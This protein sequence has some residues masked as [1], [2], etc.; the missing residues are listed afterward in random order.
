MTYLAWVIKPSPPPQPRHPDLHRHHLTSSTVAASPRPPPPSSNLL[1]RSR[2]THKFEF[3][4]GERPARWFWVMRRSWW[5]CATWRCEGGG[6]SVQ[7]DLRRWWWFCATKEV[8][9]WEWLVEWG[10]NFNEGEGGGVRCV[11]GGGIQ[12]RGRGWWWW[13]KKK[14]RKVINVILIFFGAIFSNCGTTYRSSAL[15]SVD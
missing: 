15:F 6:G 10:G 14:K 3:F 9:E 8:V 1:H 11:G 4:Y 5:L 2:V 12:A 7:C 13:F